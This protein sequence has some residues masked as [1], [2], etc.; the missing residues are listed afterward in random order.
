MAWTLDRVGQALREQLQP[1]AVPSGTAP[2]GGVSTDTRTLVRGDIFV[3]LR[4][5]RFDGHDF[6]QQAATG[7]AAVLVVD[8]PAARWAWGC[9]SSPSG[10]P[11]TRLAR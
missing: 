10:T 6:L 5:E 4:G 11:R 7:G 9:R 3:A 2:L 1:S 8:N